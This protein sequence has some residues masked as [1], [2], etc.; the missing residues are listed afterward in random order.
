M[1]ENKVPEAEVKD[2][3]FTNLSD[4]INAVVSET[5]KLADS[6]SKA[7]IATAEDISSCMIVKV[8]AETREHL[9]L[10]VEGGLASDRRSA[11]RALIQEG[12]EL[13]AATFERMRQTKEQIVALRTQ[14]RNLVE[15]HAG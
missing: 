14:M 11:A 5:T 3:P 13:K 10:L 12:I 2:K 8:D 4:A 1:T 6:L 15:T 9:D 7:I